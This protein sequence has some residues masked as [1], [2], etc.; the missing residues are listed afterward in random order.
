M[1]ASSL[2][3]DQQI[4]HEDQIVC[5]GWR[6]YVDLP[7]WGISRVRAKLDTGA[8]TSAIHVREIVEL[9]DGRL[10]FEVVLRERPTRKSVWVESEQVRQARVKPSSGVRQHRHVVET[11]MRLG[12]IT[13]TIE[14]GLVCRKGMLCRMLVGRTAL[15]GACVVDPAKRYL[16]DEGKRTHSRRKAR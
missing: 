13:R 7:S 11:T 15:Q 1:N 8:K 2:Q 3:T 14:I 12:P 10:R 5:A 4:P 16:L 6:E 9:P